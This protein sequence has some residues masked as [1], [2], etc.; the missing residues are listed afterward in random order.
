MRRQAVDVQK[1]PDRCDHKREGCRNEQLA[2]LEGAQIFVFLLQQQPANR[3]ESADY[4]ERRK[5]DDQR[6]SRPADRVIADRVIAH[7]IVDQREADDI[8]GNSD[9]APVA[10]AP[11][12]RLANAAAN[13][14]H[15]AGYAGLP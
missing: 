7:H 2:N 4:T 6:G 10:I 5:Q 1:S 9:R 15:L 11:A 8:G 14:V 12:S 13:T 3:P